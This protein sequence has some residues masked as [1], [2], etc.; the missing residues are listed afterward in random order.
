MSAALRPASIVLDNEAVTA[1]MDV[2]HPKHRRVLPF[3]EGAAQRRTRTGGPRVLVP[4]AV[5]IEAG[6]DRTARSAVTANRV[7]GAT[8]VP[9][10][11]VDADTAARFR[12][13]TDVSVVDATVAVAVVTAPRPTVVLTSDVSDLTA[14]ASL[15][16]GDVRI[17]RI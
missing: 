1:L 5:R 10:S 6:W 12:A 2:R 4:V 16:D 8:D 3:L 15:L 14:L 7:S 13:A 9:L 17:V 11:G